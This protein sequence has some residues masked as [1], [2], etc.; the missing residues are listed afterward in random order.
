[1]WL[2]NALGGI[3]RFAVRKE[4]KTIL[5]ALL[6]VALDVKLTLFLLCQGPDNFQEAGQYLSYNCAG[7]CAGHTHSNQ[8]P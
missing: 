1:M 2:P 7:L 6:P 8:R 3:R 4:A 5:F